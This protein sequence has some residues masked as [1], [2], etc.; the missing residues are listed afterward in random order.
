M[1]RSIAWLFASLLLAVAGPEASAQVTSQVT[2]HGGMLRN[3]DVSASQ[4][5][6][7]YANDLWVVD[8]EGGEATPL[9]SPPGAE[10]FARFSADGKTVA[11]MGNYEGG[12][13]LYTIPVS[14]GVPERLTHHPAT[15]RLCDWTP[16]G[17]LLFYARG[18]TGHP[19]GSQ[20]FTVS[21][22]GGLPRAL[23][24]PYGAV[25]SISPDGEWLAYTPHTRDHRSWKRY[26]GGMA[27][28]IWL[29]HLSRHESRRITEWEGTDTQPMWH[30]SMLYFLSDRGPEHRLNIWSYDTANERHRQV[31]HFKEFDVKWPSIGPG[32]KGK[33]EIVFQL[34]GALQLL[35][36]G[37]GE[38]HAVQVTIPGARPTVAMHRV[39][40]S[41]EIRGMSISSTGK[42]AAVEARGDIWTLPA[43]NGSPRNLT[44][45]S[46]VAERDPSWSPDKRWVAYFS[47]A[48]GEYELYVTQSDGKGETRKL[49]V[50]SE[51]FYSS[52]V[53][54]PDSKRI[55]I[56][57]KAGSLHLIEV[58]SGISR[59][60]D[61][62]P[63]GNSP[64]V[65][66]SHDSRWLTYSRSSQESGME[67]IYLYDTD[68]FERHRV[69][70]GMFNDESPVFDRKGDHLFFHSSRK[71]D[72]TYSDLSQSFIYEDTQL[73]IAVPLRADV[74]ASWLPKADEEKWDEDGEDNE[75]DEKDGKDKEGSKGGDADDDDAGDKSDDDGD[76]DD[77]AESGPSHPLKGRW[78][79]TVDG[80]AALGLPEDSIPISISISVADDG[81]LSGTTTAMGQTLSL[82]DVT[83]NASTGAF[84]ARQVNDGM[85]ITMTGTLS[86]G[87][88]SGKWSAEGAGV[89]GSWQATKTSSGD[90]DEEEEAE[91]APAK[92]VE[93]E[94]DGFEARAFALPVAAGSFRR[95]AVNDK[96]ALLYMRQGKGIQIF[97]LDDEEKAEK[98]VAAGAD[99]F[100]I[101]ADGKKLLVFTGGK[102]SIQGASAG[103]SG[104]PIPTGG[105]I[106]HINPR[107][108]WRQIFN[109]AWRLQ[110]DFFYVGNMHGVDW[111]KVRTQYGAMIEDCVTR[112]DVS[113]VIREMIAELNIGHAYYFGGD[114]ESAPSIGVGL[115]GVDW[116]HENG[117]HRIGHLV[118][119]AA[120]DVDAR[121]PLRASGAAV[122]EGDYLL[123]VNGIPVDAASDPWAPF[124]GTVGRTITLTVS[125]NPTLDDAARDVIVKPIGS[126]SD[127]RFREWIEQ[128]RA[129]V[130]EKTDGR[131][132]YVYVQNTGV[133]GQND[134]FRQFFGQA[135][136]DGMIIDERWNGGG[137]IPTRFIELLNRPVTNYWARRDG[138][139][140]VWPPDAHHGA[141][142]MLINGLAGSGGDMFPWLFR[143]AKLG[144]LIGT[145]TW[146]GLVGISGNPGLIDGGYTSVPTFGFYE[147]DGT[148]GVEGHGTDPD[149]EVLDDPAL[150]VDGGDPQLEAAIEH[151]LAEIRRAPHVPPRRPA[152]PDR[153]G[154]GI[155]EADQ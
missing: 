24:V 7:V 103:G 148:W 13:D 121:N 129:I 98:T 96:G 97:D 100:D 30:G 53:W 78:E 140:W 23:P 143:Q 36:L 34:G 92:R 62:D 75:D 153:S 58:E 104:K 68:A 5:V 128:N 118:E 116:S 16:D 21:A 112:D 60:I 20:L 22:N 27:T 67:S 123:A 46:G 137:Q 107:E 15:E 71:F 151:M 48:T 85:V 149:I 76:K 17:G 52:P 150:M 125:D 59:K 132:G 88:L 12:L 105:M 28:D 138:K 80:L 61:Q 65:E 147:K 101:S 144:K 134:L 55:I 130:A 44:R 11:F 141:K 63:W 10:G 82:D 8:R 31:T 19:R 56:S 146:G 126:E 109:E 99:G 122:K 1:P 114:V 77:E 64:R 115:L 145:R 106:T 43:E 127:L 133:P 45:T 117:A 131:V 57:D 93:I 37:S 142:C 42:R 69:T 74:E 6:F 41:E 152:S 102:P 120:W 14:G 94:I 70:Q 29:F 54:S 40:V 84:T 32:P 154:M 66:W 110:R 50:G 119:G 35:D 39:D 47:D 135:H 113:Y 73:L 18:I 111:P 33:G 9:A 108:E 136:L 155:S 87:A 26:R 25:G 81:S 86:D 3:P 90:D 72:P 51:T 139:D 83:F 4:I 79:G 38:A 49:T 124:V 2:P 89:G 95:L 91:D